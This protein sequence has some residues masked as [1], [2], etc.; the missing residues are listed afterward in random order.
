MVGPGITGA[1]PLWPGEPFSVTVELNQWIRF[2]CPGKY[3]VTARSTR[4]YWKADGAAAFQRISG[5]KRL[6]RTADSIFP[7]IP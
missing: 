7:G 6:N 1:P 3:R 5:T 4:A 2:G